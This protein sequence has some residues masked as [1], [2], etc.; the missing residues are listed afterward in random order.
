VKMLERDSLA[1]EAVY[2][3]YPN[4]SKLSSSLLR[5]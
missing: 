1:A 2:D 4:P 5:C 3:H